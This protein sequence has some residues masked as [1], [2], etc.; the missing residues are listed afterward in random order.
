VCVVLFA[1]VA[2]EKS[3]SKASGDMSTAD[4][5]LYRSLP[6]GQTVVFG[7]NYMK[8]QNFLNT[9]AAGKLARQLSESLGKGMKEWMDCFADLKDLKIA[10]T[11]N[12]AGRSGGEIRMVMA[13]ATLDQLVGCATKAGFKITP[14]NG[15]NYVTIEMPSPL[16]AQNQGYLKLA[17][18]ALYTRQTLS[19]AGGSPGMTTATR[20]ALE[21][22]IAAVGRNSVADDA[23]MQAIIAKA[24]RSKTVW[25]AGTGEGT[26]LSDKVGEFYASFDIS[27]GVALDA[28]VQ[29]TN[30]D[31]VKKIQDGVDQMKKMADQLPAEV[32]KVIQ[33][34]E[35]KRDGDHLR[36]VAKISDEQ[37]AELVKTANMFG[38]GLGR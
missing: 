6:A 3:G 30:S 26:P 4:L 9:S 12:V 14:A 20:D 1:L 37:I 21:A 2:C 38:A 24:D 18:G 10:G 23:K 31:L 35:V 22:D 5:D 28:T 11:V 16:G 25:F 13:G 7:G 19:F 27:P 32:K 34:L 15:G 29:V 36:F 17:S 33:D 8:L